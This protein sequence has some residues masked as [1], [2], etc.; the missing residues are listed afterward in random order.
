[1]G[2]KQAN[3]YV[4]IKIDGKSYMAH[5]LAWL[6]VN[7]EW[8]EVFVDHINGDRSDNRLINLRAA[9]REL[10][11]QNQRVAQKHNKLGILGV[12]PYGEKYYACIRVNGKTKYLGLHETP[13]VAHQAYLEAKRKYHEGCMI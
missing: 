7:G 11:A 9:T 1:M 10:N 8:P 12:S 6:D 2:N 3:G 4:Y 13:E 5:R